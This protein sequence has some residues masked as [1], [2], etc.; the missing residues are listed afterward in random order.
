MLARLAGCPAR[1]STVTIS[2][3][4]NGSSIFLFGGIGTC[5]YS[6]TLQLPTVNLPFNSISYW[7]TPLSV[8]CSLQACDQTQFLV[9]GSCTLPSPQA[10]RSQ[11]CEVL[12]SVMFKERCAPSADFS[13]RHSASAVI[14]HSGACFERFYTQVVKRTRRLRFCSVLHY[15]RCLP[16]L[17]VHLALFQQPCLEQ[18]DLVLLTQAFAFLPRVAVATFRSFC[19]PYL[20]MLFGWSHRRAT[21]ASSSTAVARMAR[22]AQTLCWLWVIAAAAFSS[23]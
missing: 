5:T 21:D 23:A 6:F 10:T 20:S 12:T 7:F 3:S 2:C 18:Q 22:P 14:T 1:Q 19:R 9:P 11:V 15:R 16:L 13:V 17:R 4:P 8:L